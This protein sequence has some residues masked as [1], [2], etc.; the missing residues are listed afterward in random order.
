[1]W[2]L[3]NKVHYYTVEYEFKTNEA[4]PSDDTPKKKG[5]G[6]CSDC[7]PPTLGLSKSGNRVVDNGFT[8]N[9]NAIQVEKWHT[10]YPLITAT[11]GELNKVEIVAYENNGITNMKM[12][13]FGL[14]AEEIGQPLSELEV[15]IEV[16]LETNGVTDYIGIDEIV[17]IDK[18]NLI[19]NESVSASAFVTECTIGDADK[20]CVKVDL[21]YSYREATIN[22]IMVVS[23][24]DKKHNN[25]NFY[26]NDGIE[27]LGD[28]INVPPTYTIQNKHSAQQTEDLT[29]T[30][31]DRENNIWIDDSSNNNKWQQNDSD[32]FIQLTFNEFVRYNDKSTSIM[33]RVHSDFG[34]I[35]Q[36]EED[37]AIII[38]D[39]MKIQSE[40]SSS[41]AYDYPTPEQQDEDN[42]FLISQM[43]LEELKAQKI[44]N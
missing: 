30:R 22:N 26:F 31:V 15:L 21:E 3:G 28:S 9:G 18:E 4:P 7:T 16:H 20:N 36:Y 6:G 40:L 2:E 17:I 1:M 27:V 38:F 10:P 33:T 34:K 25:Q 43:Y 8:Y 37:K 13:Q 5:S 42:K 11:V 41:V 23:T 32:T 12:I 39:S 19:E 29:L 35:L 44:L 14:G 24:M